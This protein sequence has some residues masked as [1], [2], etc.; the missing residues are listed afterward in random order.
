MTWAIPILASIAAFVALWL[1]RPERKWVAILASALTLVAGAWEAGFLRAQ[2][3]VEARI[4][5]NAHYRLRLATNRFKGAIKLLVSETD[6]SWQPND[7]NEFFSADTAAGICK[8]DPSAEAR[9]LP[10]QRWDNYFSNATSELKEQLDQ[11][12]FNQAAFL[13][14]DLVKSVSALQQ[15]SAISYFIQMSRAMRIQHEIAPERQQSFC[16]GLEEL[17]SEMLLELGRLHSLL[18]RKPAED[19]KV[20]SRP[21]DELSKARKKRSEE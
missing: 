16:Q 10:R 3:Q 15:S 11:V 21:W 14:S 7:A 1:S 6:A 8:V 19:A 17:V 5:A 20:V 13:D 4:E 9:V 18:L 2:N 12:I